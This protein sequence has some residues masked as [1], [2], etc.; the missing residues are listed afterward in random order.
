MK[1]AKNKRAAVQATNEAAQ[2]PNEDMPEGQD[3]VNPQSDEPR[4]ARQFS[5]AL[6]Y[7]R[8]SPTNKASKLFEELTAAKESGNRL[9]KTIKQM[10]S[11]MGRG[12]L[13]Q[14]LF[15]KV[16]TDFGFTPELFAELPKK[17]QRQVINTVKEKVETP[18]AEETPAEPA[19][20]EINLDD[21][22]DDD[23]VLPDDD[24][25]VLPDDDEKPK[26]DDDQLISSKDTLE[27]LNMAFT[28]LKQRL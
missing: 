24:D 7:Q 14:E 25:I 20:P 8:F 22:E 16:M 17:K 1:G 11:S 19:E 12:S 15:N 5:E 4:T 21:E 2:G 18:A 3:V 27:S 26:D 13:T 23:I 9:D 6:G 28:F 10:K